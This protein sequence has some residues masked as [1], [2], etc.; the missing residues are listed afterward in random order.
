[1][2][3]AADRVFKSRMS[4]WIAGVYWALMMLI[5]SLML[6]MVFLSGAPQSAVR[7][8]LSAFAFVTL[9]F[10]YILY[11]AYTLTFT[12]TQREVAV[13]G[14]FM[15]FSIRLSNIKSVEKTLI[16]VGVKVAGASLL[17]GYY[18]IF[19]LGYARV[20]MTN[21]ND[22]VLITTKRKTGRG[23][24]KHYVITPRDPQRFIRL[25]RSRTRNS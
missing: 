22:G 2:A 24:V 18:Y 21:F 20:A 14:I 1:M 10:G 6:L 16:P 15:R 12:V 8:L 11:K 9:L 5:G 17:G 23:R 19:G 4:K 25:V 3:K 13:S 7:I